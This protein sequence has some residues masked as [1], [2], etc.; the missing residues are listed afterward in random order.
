M[1]PVH[2]SKAF[3]SVQ[4]SG[5]TQRDLSALLSETGLNRTADTAD[6]STGGVTAKKY[7]AG[8]IDATSSLAGPFDGTLDGYLAPILG[9][10]R[11]FIYRPQGA[12]TGL[13]E[14]TGSGFLATYE[15]TTSMDD[16]G[17]MSGEFQVSGPVTRTI[18]P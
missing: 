6:V 3:F 14:Y 13:V 9:M 1:P 17:Q 18:Q 4:D 12:G 11:A 5:G 2:G 10:E 15:V 8:L 16:A 7:I